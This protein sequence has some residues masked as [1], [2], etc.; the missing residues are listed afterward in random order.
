MEGD[1]VPIPIGKS[2]TLRSG[3]SVALLAV[4]SLVQ[5]ALEAA[6]TLAA[7]GLECEVV[8]MRFVKPLDQELLQSVWE[9]HNLVFTL[10]ENALAGGFGAA[11]LEW[12]VNQPT[13][14]GP[15]IVPVGI[16]DQFQ[17]HA[18]RAE[19]MADMGLDAAGVAERIRKEVDVDAGS[20]TKAQSA[21]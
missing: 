12:A 13:G 21:S 2:E 7:E 1:P 16:P 14:T 10:E 20:H 11:V 17:E 5:P 15:R 9:R 18:S 3:D 19:L 8:D 4:G 6:E